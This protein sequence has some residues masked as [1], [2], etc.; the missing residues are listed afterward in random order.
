ML[1]P[2]SKTVFYMTGQRV[3]FFVGR[4]ADSRRTSC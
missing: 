3:E 4:E 1:V 2:D